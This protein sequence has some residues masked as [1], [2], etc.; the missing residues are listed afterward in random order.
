MIFPLQIAGLEP[1]QIPPDRFTPLLKL[2]G[3]ALNSLTL[4]LIRPKGLRRV[5]VGRQTIPEPE[6]LEPFEANQKARAL[7]V[8]EAAKLRQISTPTA[9][10]GIWVHAREKNSRKLGRQLKMFL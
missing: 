2:P 10:W 5:P 3:F 1:F 6:I 4:H 7:T 9:L 8:V